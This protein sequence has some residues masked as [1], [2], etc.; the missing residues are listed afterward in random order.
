MGYAHE[1]AHAVLHRGRVPMEP[2]DHVVN[3]A[4]GPRRGK[5]YP[6]AEAFALPETEDLPDVPIAPGLLPGAAGGPVP[7]PR[8]G[9][10]LPLLSAMLKDSYGLTGR[11]LGVQANTDLAGL[12]YYHHANW[13][14]G[15]AGGGGLYPVSVHWASGPSGPLTPGL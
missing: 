11:R 2:T 7:E 1:Y 5:Y 4:D 9:F 6:R 15:T 14:R 3:W 8:A 13:S 10:G 12:P